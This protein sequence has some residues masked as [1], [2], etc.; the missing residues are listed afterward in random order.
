MANGLIMVMRAGWEKEE[1]GSFL[2]GGGKR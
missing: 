1:G 2:G